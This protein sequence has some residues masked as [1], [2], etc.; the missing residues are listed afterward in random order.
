M[1]TTIGALTQKTT[2]AD[3]DL[4]E[5]E[6][7]Q[8]S[9]NTA[10]KIT[11]NSLVSAGDGLTESG[12]TLAVDTSNSFTPTWAGKHQFD[13]ETTFS[14][15]SQAYVWGVR[16]SNTNNLS[17]A[18]KGD[19]FILSTLTPTG[20][21]S[22]QNLVRMYAEGSDPSSDS[23]TARLTFGYSSGEYIFKTSA[24]GTGTHKPIN[25]SV[26]GTTDQLVLAT[27]GHSEFNGEPGGA[28]VVTRVKR[29]TNAAGSLWVGSQEATA[30]SAASRIGMFGHDEAG[31]ETE[32]TRLESQVVTNTDGSEDGSFHINTIQGGSMTEVAV[33]DE[34][35]NVGVG[36][37][38]GN[39]GVGLN[40]FLEI[41]DSRSAS[42]DAGLVLDASDASVL[43]WA[44]GDSVQY[45]AQY[46]PG[47]T[48]WK[49]RSSNA[50]SYIL[51]IQDNETSLRLPNIPSGSNNAVHVDGNKQLIENTSTRRHKTNYRPADV[52]VDA[53]VSLKPE[54]YRRTDNAPDR[55]FLALTVEP[56]H[57]AGF[58]NALV[59]DEG[60]PRT[61]AEGGRGIDAMQQA[62]LRD[63]HDQLY[64]N[65]G[66][67][68]IDRLERENKALR[69]ALHQAD[70]PIPE[71]EPAS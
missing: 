53:A 29:T 32:Y 39:A 57:E 10:K 28:G 9:P 13:A 20:D 33:F 37:R 41:E 40:T 58:E 25:L 52:D 46:L 21:G 22:E 7:T 18:G 1:P 59:Y 69:E 26:G 50:S 23:D 6:D 48:S 27:D 15:G 71:P 43:V 62:V 12:R 51:A 47:D 70:I 14:P 35:G 11:V 65:E 45:R 67:S 30:G 49:L 54:I 63:H 4:L 55:E 3:A 44:N 66:S 31:N 8:T 38:P 5:I 56:F 60:R 16:T 36:S 24:S 19:R 64:T 61:F 68:R 34:N 17:L 42:N 2:P